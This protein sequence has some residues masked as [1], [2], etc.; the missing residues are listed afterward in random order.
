MQYLIFF[1]YN[2]GGLLHYVNS[3]LFFFIPVIDCSSVTIL[4]FFIPIVDRNKYIM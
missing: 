2:V 4:F 1:S 3:F